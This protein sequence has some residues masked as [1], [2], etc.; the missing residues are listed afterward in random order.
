[1]TAAPME[2]I[3]QVTAILHAHVT[4][5]ATDI[6]PLRGGV[7]SRAFAF[8]TDGRGYVIRLSAFGHA[9][10]SFAKDEY[11]GR[12]FASPA[13]PIPT[14]VARGKD[15]DDFFVV[16]ERA[17]G[18]IL[19][20]LSPPERQALFPAILETLD[21]IAQTDVRGTRGYG[22]WDATGTGE[23]ATWHDF[24]AAI[25]ENTATGFYRDWHTLFRDSFLQR[26]VFETIY[27][28]MLRLAADCPE[29]RAL[30]HNDFH[31]ENVLA[32]GGHITGVIDWGN[33]L[34]GDPLHEIAQLA[35]WSGW[36]GWWYDDSAPLLRERYGAT[37]HYDERIACYT[38]HVALDELRYNA[39]VG[40]RAQYERARDR[41]LTL[42][43]SDTGQRPAS[44]AG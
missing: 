36:P 21:T 22:D 16:S 7:F 31:F 33:A 1:M 29:E 8:T 42:I 38:C 17:A 2:E 44:T 43:A 10:A 40:N 25:I 13:L 30:I 34:Y 27:R 9:A 24:L 15:A 35:W 41:I 32:D 14:V 26:D 4:T 12:H 20:A 18:R 5:E 23:T 3:A 19:D 39:R 6:E 37:A 28:H 11:A